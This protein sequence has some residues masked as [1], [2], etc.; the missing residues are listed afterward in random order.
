[1]KMK[2]KKNER[3]RILLRFFEIGEI[4]EEE[5]ERELNDD[6]WDWGSRDDED[7]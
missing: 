7:E 4:S 6:Y 1:M 2:M 3:E 5:Y